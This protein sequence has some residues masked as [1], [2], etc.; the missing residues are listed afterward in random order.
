MMPEVRK[1]N[2][3]SDQ[4]KRQA[5]YGIFTKMLGFF[6]S[7]YNNDQSDQIMRQSLHAGVSVLFND[8]LFSSEDN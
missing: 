3:S 5:Q 1:Q 8:G 6:D 2:K 7:F 4:K